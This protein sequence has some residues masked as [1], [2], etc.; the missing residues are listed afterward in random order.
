MNILVIQDDAALAK[1]LRHA[2]EREGHQVHIWAGQGLPTEIKDDLVLLDISVPLADGI[3]VLRTLR[4]EKPGVLIVVLTVRERSENLSQYLDAGA[5]DCLTKPFLY[6]ELAARIR[7]L[8][9]RSRVALHSVLEVGDLRLD[10]M[11]RHVERAG[12]S[13]ELTAKEFS[14]LEYLMRNAGTRVTR[15]D[16]IHNVWKVSLSPAAT[17]VVDVYIAYGLRVIEVI[18]REQAA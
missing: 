4:R 6:G 5:D 9:R 11:E 2:L 15:A 12:K 16:I 1:F 17:N 14:L 13:I 18:H 8:R 10:R 3:P 7:V